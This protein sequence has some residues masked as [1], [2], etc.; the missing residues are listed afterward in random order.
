MI[1]GT[2][3]TLLFNLPIDTATI[4]SAEVMVQYVDSNKEVTIV[5]TLDEC[6]VT[7]KTI[8]ARLTQEETLQLPAPSAVAIQLR[9]LTIDDVALASVIFTTTV[10][11]LLKEGVIE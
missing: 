9:V 2:T 6:E 7:E 8:T 3:P 11:K 5:K 10:K 4:K 1:K